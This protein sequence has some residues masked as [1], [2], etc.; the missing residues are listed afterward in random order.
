MLC[1]HKEL[2]TPEGVGTFTVMECLKHYLD[3]STGYTDLPAIMKL[4]W[5]KAEGSQTHDKFYV[6]SQDLLKYHMVWIWFYVH[7]FLK[8]YKMDDLKN[9][10]ISS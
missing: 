2:C 9:T 4:C 5:H 6:P 8:N 7:F 3:C 1:A 10:R